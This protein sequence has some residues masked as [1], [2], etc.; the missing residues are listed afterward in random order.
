MLDHAAAALHLLSAA[1]RLRDS[2]VGEGQPL[3]T[4][5]VQTS[6]SIEG[7]HVVSA[8]WLLGDIDIAPF[9]RAV[10]LRAMTV[11]D[12]ETLLMP[13]TAPAI[14]TSRALCAAAQ[15][16]WSSAASQ[17]IGAVNA[18]RTN[19][20]RAIAAASV[21]KRLQRVKSR[22]SSSTRTWSSPVIPSLNLGVD[23]SFPGG[24]N[25]APALPCS[26]LCCT[27]YEGN[28]TS[29][30]DNVVPG[31]AS[32]SAAFMLDAGLAASASISSTP[33][34]PQDP[35]LLSDGGGLAD[36]LRRIAQ[37]AL[38]AAALTRTHQGIAF[39][40]RS[41][42]PP[43][44]LEAASDAAPEWALEREAHERL[45]A[46]C[47]SESGLL[48]GLRAAAVRYW[49]VL[50][51]TS[52][53]ISSIGD[54]SSR[55]PA[56]SSDA[57]EAARFVLQTLA[58]Q[59]SDDSGGS[60]VLI[61]ADTSGHVSALIWHAT[62]EDASPLR[63]DLMRLLQDVLECDVAAPASHI[64][65]LLPLVDGN[66][67][68]APLV[69]SSSIGATALTAVV[70]R[71]LQQAA[72]AFNLGVAADDARLSSSQPHHQ[73]LL[74]ASDTSGAEFA[75]APVSIP[76]MTQM[77]LV[78]RCISVPVDTWMSISS[79]LDVS[80]LASLFRC[81]SN[82]VHVAAALVHVCRDASNGISIN[83][84]IDPS[85]IT[86]VPPAV[87]LD[88]GASA[89][90]TADSA[91]NAVRSAAAAAAAFVLAMQVKSCVHFLLPYAYFF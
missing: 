79:T 9:V 41:A 76:P 67:A 17:W 22:P 66:D 35:A 23:V 59:F 62:C 55:L 84:T 20:L 50:R 91:M 21:A 38:H 29:L 31:T 54:S 4:D 78:S 19:S 30:G 83:S 34:T 65:T 52:H 75:V 90:V 58:A 10:T 51:G 37:D 64:S 61:Y 5:D 16:L 57:L 63:Y 81:R 47:G 8:C 70:S 53:S 87:V 43:V 71:I 69:G 48:H 89:T 45:R 14:E 18:A 36:L 6:L 15:R 3:C 26:C 46:V 1:T 27:S 80:S 74:S 7:G 40:C 49:Q 44:G 72:R 11:S 60:P 42:D 68:F 77:L 32:S 86:P 39:A 24:E 2:I 28:D 33:L 56:S 73:W 82:L 88:E 25:L 12:S 13:H 85:F